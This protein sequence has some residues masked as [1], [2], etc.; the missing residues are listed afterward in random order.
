MVVSSFFVT[1]KDG[2]ERFFEES[3]L[4]AN[5]KLD[6]VLGILFL[7]INNVDIDFQAWD[8]Q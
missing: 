1:D 2:K 3:F 8:L 6:I 5:V 7:T 4:L